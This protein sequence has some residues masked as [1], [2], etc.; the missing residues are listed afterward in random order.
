MELIS[1]NFSLKM[2]LNGNTKEIYNKNMLVIYLD[3]KRNLNT[4][5]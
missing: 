2:T 1:W 4:I 3:Y 5:K